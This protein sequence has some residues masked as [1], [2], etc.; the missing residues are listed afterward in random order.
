MDPI[1]PR[2]RNLVDIHIAYQMVFANLAANM[3]SMR[4]FQVISYRQR[5]PST[6]YVR[7]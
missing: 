1:E 3:E 7:R 5:I 6:E 2:M 4:N